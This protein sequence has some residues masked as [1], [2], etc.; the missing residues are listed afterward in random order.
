MLRRFRLALGTAVVLA[1]AMGEAR[2]Q[3]YP[4]YGSYGWS[5]WSGWGG[6]ST[7]QG[8]IARGLGY[9]NIGAGVYNEKTAIANSINTDTVTR[10]NQYLWLSQQEA[11]RREYTRRA[12]RQQRDSLTGDLIYKQLLE[13]PTPRDIQD[14]DALNV[15]LDQVTDPRIHTSA[16]RMATEPLD[17]EII[18]DIPFENAS[19]GVTLSL[20][21]LTAQGAWPTALAG[22]DFA[23]ERAAY[24]A[25]V[26][27]ALKEDEEGQIS[28]PTLA[29]VT[30]AVDRLRAKLQ[31]NPPIDRTQ[32]VEAQNY[33][34]TLAGMSRMLQRPQ[35]ER[36]LSEL[37]KVDKTSLGSLLGFMHT[38]NLRF[39]PSTT[40]EQ[41]AIYERLY[42]PM[43][44]LRDKIVKDT[45]VAPTPPVA[46]TPGHPSEFFQGMH[47]DH[48]SGN[49][50]PDNP[51]PPR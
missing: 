2:A 1:T 11:N 44:G 49:K 43:V 42:P 31:A 22:N 29:S 32:L 51:P 20:H 27:Q 40:P 41:R 45:G 17:S 23:P 6:G 13:N 10:W 18:D 4:G 48:L 39:G 16:L 33:V 8:D 15:I 14:G 30:V 38:Y 35:T 50:T 46:R 37:K 9:Y 12:R 28:G 3:Y 47:L 24:Q 26:A 7:A 25:A 19:E 5:G 21:Q 34:R 36:A